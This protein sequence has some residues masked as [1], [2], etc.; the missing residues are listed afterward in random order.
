MSTELLDIATIE[1]DVVN[2]LLARQ[3]ANLFAILDACD[4]PRIP[5]KAYELGEKAACLY[6]GKA[7]WTQAALAPY[8]VLVKEAELKWIMDN[9]AGTFWGY[10]LVTST[11]VTLPALRTHLRRFLTVTGPSGEELYFRFY[12]PRV[13]LDFLQTS[14]HQ[15][16][17]QFFGPIETILIQRYESLV[18]A[19]RF[20][21]VTH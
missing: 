3:D 10:Y 18:S 13:I 9:L 11:S 5:M 2:Q 19:Q 12:D 21:D 16:L 20:S 17:D 6:H 14:S 1:L 8:L 15:E 4:E 7:A